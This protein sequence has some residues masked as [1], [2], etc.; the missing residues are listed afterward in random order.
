MKSIFALRRWYAAPLMPQDSAYFSSV[1]NN[2]DSSENGGGANLLPPSLSTFSVPA[3]SSSL[4]EGLASPANV[5]LTLSLSTSSSGSPQMRCRRPPHGPQQENSGVVVLSL[6]WHNSPAAHGMVCRQV[7]A[8][9]RNTQ[10]VVLC[11]VQQRVW[12][13]AAAEGAPRA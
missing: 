7:L 12:V 1:P 11:C 13:C 3:S 4:S 10:R 6:S 8:A 2:D 9:A 5:P